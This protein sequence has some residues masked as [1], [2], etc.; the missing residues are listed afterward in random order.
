LLPLLKSEELKKIIEKAKPAV[1]K[2]FV[3]NLKKEI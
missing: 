3:E 1:G 2:K